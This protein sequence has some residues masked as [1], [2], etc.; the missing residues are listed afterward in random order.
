M[1]NVIARKILERRK[2]LNL[3]QRELSG[4][5]Y[6]V[7]YISQIENGRVNP[8]ID[9]LEH[10][11]A[12]LKVPVTYLIDENA[13][14]DSV[15]LTSA[16]V[17]NLLDK[18][19]IMP[20]L[21]TQERYEEVIE[22]SQSIQ[23]R[24]IDSN[25]ERFCYICDYYIGKAYYYQNMYS[26]TIYYLQKC[27]NQLKY[28]LVLNEYADCC[29][30]LGLSFI[31]SVNM[32][33]AEKYFKQALSVID[34]H[35]LKL[36]ELRSKCLVNIATISGNTNNYMSAFEQYT[37]IVSQAK[38]G[39]ISPNYV[40]D[41]YIGLASC[42][43]QLDNLDDALKFNEQALAIYGL[44]HDQQR[45]ALIKNN[46]GHIYYRLGQ[47]EPAIDNYVAAT[48]IYQE[49]DRQSDLAICYSFL[50][51]SYLAIN[52]VSEAA[53]FAESAYVQAN[54]LQDKVALAFA[55]LAKGFVL[56][57][58]NNP[59]E[60]INTLETAEQLFLESGKLNDLPELYN[61]LGNLYFETGNIDAGKAA[62][63]KAMAQLL[64]KTK[65]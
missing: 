1:P 18:L 8:P 43:L 40:A 33:S 49:L 56:Q 64:N 30:L 19:I 52:N 65:K 57:A 28:C 14:L 42:N 26:D 37:N 63:N 25:L 9:T 21:I 51:R 17:D 32:K 4:E 34:T 53:H 47:F 23:Q 2:E 35:N 58:Q 45:L 27:E 16:F 59:A 60:A 24:F 11:A 46:F 55:C 48:N 31:Y 39:K 41:A 5:K 20:T 12:I 15:N 29:L 13:T 54:L 7:G 3:R 6:T 10:I 62:F 50:A 36:Y 44:L 38:E 61:K 22:K